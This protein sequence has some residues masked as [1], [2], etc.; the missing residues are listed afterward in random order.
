MSISVTLADVKLLAFEEGSS[1]DTTV[2]ALMNLLLPAI[3]EHLDTESVTEYSSSNWVKLAVTKIIAGEWV[4][5]RDRLVDPDTTV[6]N[7]T[8]SLPLADRRDDPSG[9]ITAGWNA[10]LP[11]V[12]EELFWLGSAEWLNDGDMEG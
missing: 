7:S 4:A 10:L 3:E 12:K 9:L 6:I 8:L 1:N 11:L 2:T 5:R